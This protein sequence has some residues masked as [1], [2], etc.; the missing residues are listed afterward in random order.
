MAA[1]E[2]D[3]IVIGGG[4]T[5]ENV[6]DRAVKGGLRAVVVEADLVGGECSYWACIPSK[7]LLRPVQAL[8]E[9]QNVAG[10][11]E[12]ITRSLDVPAVLARRDSFT[13]HWNDAGQVNWLR[14][15]NIDLIRGHA[16]LVVSAAS[17]SLTEVAKPLSLQHAMQ[18]HFVR[19]AVRRF[20]PFPA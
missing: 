7:A 19:V 11:R 12:A 3:V 8:A 17:Q 15:A 6:A 4:S 18:L 9:A 1:R 2:Y 14:G 13:A 16:R 5:G 10:A 20:P